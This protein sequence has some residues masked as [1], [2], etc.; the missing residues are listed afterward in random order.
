VP[1]YRVTSASIFWIQKSIKMFIDHIFEDH[2]ESSNS[3][4]ETL[5]SSGKKN[6]ISNEKFI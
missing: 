4:G 1:K 6:F 5:A 2:V 3:F